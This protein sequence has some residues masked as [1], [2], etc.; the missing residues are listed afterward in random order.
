MNEKPTHLDLFS[1]IGGFSLAFEAE[2]FKTIGFAEI[3]SYAS[4]VLKKHWPNVTNY[5]DVRNVPAVQCDTI[6]G[7]FPCQPF[8][9]AGKR[10]GKADDR[11]LWPQMLAVIERCRP[12]WALCENVPGIISMELDRVL[13]DLELLNYSCQSF[14]VPACAV[15][16]KHRRDRLWIVGE[17]MADAERTRLEKRKQQSAWEEC[18]AAKRGCKT[19]PDTNGKPKIRATE[20]RQKHYEWPIEPELG[21]VA[22]G[23]PNRAH[24]IRCLGN[25]IVPQV[26]Q[27]FARA[28]Y[29][30]IAF[31]NSNP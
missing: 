30:Q 23:I 6:T 20:S 14:T 27:I 21:R 24:R 12:A 18:E 13:S 4:A 17:N 22:H 8:S 5:G 29:Q 7:G 9:L 1:G 15:D 26:A 11:F 2:G 10:S 3:D 19:I 31:E 28:I 25:S 16:A